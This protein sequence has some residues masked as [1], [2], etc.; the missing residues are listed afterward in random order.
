VVER[1][2]GSAMTIDE[3]NAF[4][5][6]FVIYVVSMILLPGTKYDHTSFD[7]WDALVDLYA[8]HTFDWCEYI[9]CCLFDAVVKV[10]ADIREMV[11]QLVLLV[12]AYSCRYGCACMSEKQLYYLCVYR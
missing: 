5:G 2:Y 1:E 9:I 10:K 4:K 8:I 3:E 11:K 6:T 12:V 7:Y